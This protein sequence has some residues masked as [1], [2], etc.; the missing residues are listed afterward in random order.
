MR[1]SIESIVAELA[2]CAERY[3]L[4]G[5]PPEIWEQ[6]A[7]VMRDALVSLGLDPSEEEVLKSGLLAS[8]LAL[9]HCVNS[10]IIMGPALTLCFVQA[11]VY[12][13][14]ISGEMPV[15]SMAD[16]LELQAMSA[17]LK[18]QC[19]FAYAHEAGS[20][21]CTLQAHGPEQMHHVWVAVP[22]DGAAMLREMEIEV[23]HG[24]NTL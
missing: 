5:V 13:K 2:V 21:R 10:H 12:A 8:Y 11:S 3:N 20:S 23:E 16:I 19:D 7:A 4:A 14:W 15:M 17:L 24:E 1:I 9:G 22:V 6:N 18:P